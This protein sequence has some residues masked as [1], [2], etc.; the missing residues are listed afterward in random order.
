MS[1]TPGTIR[2]VAI[3]MDG[4]GRWAE[5]RG[6]SRSEG[7]KAGAAAV[8]TVLKSAVRNHVEYLTL[9]AFSTEN[10]KRPATEVS[11]LMGLLADFMLNKLPSLMENNI[12]L[13][14]VG[15]TSGLPLLARNRLL[16]AVEKTRKNTGCTL[17]LALNYGG[18]AEI[19]DAASAIARDAASGVLKADDIDEKT[20][21]GYLYDPELP[22]VDLMIRTSGELR[23]S[24]FLLWELAYAELYVTPKLWP[25]FNGDDFDEALD[26]FFRRERRFGDV[27]SKQK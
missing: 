2:H 15:R 8:D 17:V 23:L 3:I 12:R 11:A 1:G 6:L 18:R 26:V 24:N 21:A 4:N 27:G 10:W 7:H 5:S 9:Y 25:D 22:D 19:A 13:K 14:T 16:A 20:F